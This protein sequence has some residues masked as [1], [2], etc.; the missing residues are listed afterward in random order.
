MMKLNKQFIKQCMLATGMMGT[1]LMATLPVHADEEPIKIGVMLPYSG[2]YAGLGE[3]ATNGLKQALKEHG[4]EIAGRP[5]E[6]MISD[7]E[8]KPARAPELTSA[9]ADKDD[10]DFIV[11]PV[12]SGVA[13]GMIKTIRNKDSI[14]IIPNAGANAATGAF[15][16]PNVFRTSFSSWQTAYPM[17][18]EAVEMGY[19]KV[20]TM[21]WNYG[22]GKESLEAFE[23]SYE[24]AGGEVVKKIYVPFPNTEFQSYLT[25]IASIKPD[26][27]FVFF[28]GGGSVKFV[29]DYD[30]LGLKGKIPLIGSGF[31]TE[32]TIEAQGDSAEGLLTTLHYAD[33]LDNPKNKA[34]REHYQSLY[35]K[36]ADLYAVQ[37][38]DA[39]QLIIQAVEATK[40]NT[41]DKDALIKAMEKVEIDSPRG[42]FR[43]SKAHNPIQNIYLRK[44]ENGENVVVKTAA[45]ELSDPA[46][47]CRL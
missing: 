2:V 25:E 32:G 30:A 31:L 39:G 44:V 33:T 13:M 24:K 43:F 47:G 42:A 38:Y 11:G 23:E 40:G 22:F 14:M 45:S 5:V 19:K 28:A 6:F 34:F 9:M 20:V 26:A 4:N 12:H 17:G 16:Q 18:S 1:T 7:T 36:P 37:G 35:N 46:R 41:S 8:A 27:V 10:A 3:A 21:S 29:K 15:C